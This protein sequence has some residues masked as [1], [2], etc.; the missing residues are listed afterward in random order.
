MYKRSAFRSYSNGIFQQ[1]DGVPMELRLGP[2][3]AG[4]FVLELQT[5]VI[6]TLGRP[7]LKWKRY[8]DDTF[9]YVKIGTVND[10]L[11]KLNGFHQNIK[12]I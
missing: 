10:I 1:N 9:C 3:L 12:F 7:L 5:S 2:V 6:P 8:V 11:I 4:I